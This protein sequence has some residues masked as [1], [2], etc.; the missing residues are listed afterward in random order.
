MYLRARYLRELAARLRVDP[1]DVS[2]GLLLGQCGYLRSEML[3]LTRDASLAQ[4]R[5]AKI[6]VSGSTRSRS[7][8]LLRSLAR[9]LSDLRT[10]LGRT[11]GD[12]AKLSAPPRQ[13]T[14]AEIHA[15][16]MAAIA[17]LPPVE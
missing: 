4:V 9:Q 11:E 14:D 12:L 7:L 3:R 8:R 2:V 5:L 13:M 1:R 17:A 10:S 15:R 16:D 6:T